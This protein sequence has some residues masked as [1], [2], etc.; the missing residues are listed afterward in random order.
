MYSIILFVRKEFILIAAI[1]CFLIDGASTRS[2]GDASL[3]WYVREDFIFLVLVRYSTFSIHTV[4]D[5]ANYTGAL[6]VCVCVCYRVDRVHR[7]A[8]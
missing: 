8:S 6:S 2:K 4:T 7:D 5:P 1:H 3:K